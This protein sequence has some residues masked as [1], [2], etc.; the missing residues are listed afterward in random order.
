VEVKLRERRRVLDLPGA[1]GAHEREKCKYD[2]R[3]DLTSVM[4]YVIEI[5]GFNS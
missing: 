3:V 4:H 5:D 2:H 1:C